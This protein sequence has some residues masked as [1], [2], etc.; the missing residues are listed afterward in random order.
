[1]ICKRLTLTAIV[2]A[3][4]FLSA[5]AQTPITA[6]E[7]PTQ[8]AYTS[9]F[10]Q[11]DPTYDSWWSLFGDSKLDTLIA[12]GIAN[13]YDLLAAASRIKIAQAQLQQARAAYFP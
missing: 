6:E 3:A 4:G 7:M 12:R 9:E 13:N 10:V 2:A 1:M 8:W 11:Q 5:A